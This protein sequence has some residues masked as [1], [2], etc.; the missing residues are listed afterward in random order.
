MEV[1]PHSDLCILCPELVDVRVGDGKA[2]CYKDCPAAVD[3]GG[4]WGCAVSPRH[5]CPWPPH[6]CLPTSAASVTKAP[7]RWAGAP[8]VH[9]S[10]SALPDRVTKCWPWRET[11]QPLVRR[12]GPLVSG[13]AV[14]H[15]LSIRAKY[16][17]HF[18]FSGDMESR[19][20]QRRGEKRC[21]VTASR[22]WNC[23]DTV[24]L[25]RRPFLV[26]SVA[27]HQSKSEPSCTPW[28]RR[29]ETSSVF[30]VKQKLG[31]G[32]RFH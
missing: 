28:R 18:P 19:P 25:T 6:P 14:L 32:D 1:P 4:L 15:N 5:V 2:R 8:P 10:Q 17:C 27:G 26:R 3:S 12:P 21:Y 31:S 30:S 23:P 9:P 29:R 16:I 24:G 11:L 22:G 20:S 13:F 7:Q